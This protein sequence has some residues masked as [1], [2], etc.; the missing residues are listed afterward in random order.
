MGY[1]HDETKIGDR[2]NNGGVTLSS[3]RMR[4]SDVLA[5]VRDR[6]GGQVCGRWRT[7]GQTGLRRWRSKE[8][9][10]IER[11]E[12]GQCLRRAALAGGST[13]RHDDCVDGRGGLLGEARRRDC[14]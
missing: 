10:T 11:P 13:A 4:S 8:L 14:G 7:V 9:A 3:S 2:V 6:G 12:A 5:Q 1:S